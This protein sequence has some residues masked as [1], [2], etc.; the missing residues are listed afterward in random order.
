[1]TTL[2]DGLENYKYS[3]HYPT[4]TTQLESNGR[5]LLGMIDRYKQNP[6]KTELTEAKQFLID[7]ETWKAN[8]LHDR[9]GNAERN[10]DKAVWNA[11]Y[12]AMQATT[13]E[14]RLLAIMDLHGFG[15]SVDPE[16]GLR[17]GKLASSVLRF[18]WPEEWGVVDWRNQAMF[19]FLGKHQGNIDAAIDEA[20]ISNA[21]QM[22]KDF[23]I[24]NEKATC[25]LNGHYRKLAKAESA[26]PRAADVDMAI[27]GL[28]LMAWTMP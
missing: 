27:F 9:M 13:D 17:R 12:A 25:E 28:S 16:T 7:I 19:L 15:K 5:D 26:L 1:M 20:R 24:M 6:G 14:M 10:S 3:E 22:R 21:N 4:S 2:V 11:L 23:D 18:L 8:C